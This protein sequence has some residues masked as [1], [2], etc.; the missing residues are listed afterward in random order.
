M[1][2]KLLLDHAHCW[3]GNRLNWFGRHRAIKR[4]HFPLFYPQTYYSTRVCFFAVSVIHT[5]VNSI[6]F[7]HTNWCS[8]NQTR[9]K[10]GRCE[11]GRQQSSHT[12]FS[13]GLKLTRDL[14]ETLPIAAA[15]T[16]HKRSCSQ[17]SECA[18]CSGWCPLSLLEESGLCLLQGIT[19]SLLAHSFLQRLCPVVQA[20]PSAELNLA[21]N[22]LELSQRFLFRCNSLAVFTW[23]SSSLPILFSQSF[24]FST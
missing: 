3:T 19:M 15:E 10:H 20:K 23:Q 17:G 12:S 14:T 24:L 8:L 1:T 6:I 13:A 2:V 22:I 18:G 16:S 21:L 5:D 7:L 11:P 9:S 4:K